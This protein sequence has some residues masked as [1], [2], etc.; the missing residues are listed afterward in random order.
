MSYF[1][2]LKLTKLGETLLANINGNLNETLTFTSGEIGAGI[3]NNDD[4]I[5][6]LTTLKEK[7]KD[8]D[9]ISIEKDEKDETIVK[10]EL[11]FSNIDLKEAKI[12]REIGIYAKGNNGEP[13]L[14]AYSNAGENY[15]YIPLPQ[16]NPQNFTIQINLKITSNSKIDAIINMAGFVTIGKMIEYL[17]NKLTQIPTIAE[18]QSRKNLKI[19]DIVEVLGYYSAGDGAGH[20]RII[21]NEDDGSGVQLNNGLWANIVHNGEVN[22][23]WFG[24]KG[25]GITD[26]SDVLNKII[27][28]CKNNN[29]NDIKFNSN[30]FYLLNKTIYINDLRSD[31]KQKR[32]TFDM[33]TKD[34]REGCIV[35]NT[36]AEVFKFTNCNCVDINLCVLSTKHSDYNSINFVIPENERKGCSIV[37]STGRKNKNGIEGSAHTFNFNIACYLEDNPSINKGLG[38][39]AIYNDTCE[40]SNYNLKN[41]VANTWCVL[42]RN[43]YL[44]K[45]PEN[46]YKKSCKDHWITSKIVGIYKNG[47]VFFID[48][49]DN[50]YFNGY[51][52]GSSSKSEDNSSF[53]YLHGSL[54]NFYIQTDIEHISYCIRGKQLN[55]GEL[56]VIG[57]NIHSL[58]KLKQLLNVNVVENTYFIKN[59]NV[60]YEPYDNSDSYVTNFNLYL[61]NISHLNPKK[62]ISAT[63]QTNFNVFSPNREINYTDVIKY[64][65]NE[66]TKEKAPIK[67]HTDRGVYDEKNRVSFQYHF[68]V[69]TGEFQLKAPGSL[70]INSAANSSI[71]GKGI[72]YYYRGNGKYSTIGQQGYRTIADANVTTPN[73]IGE[74]AIENGKLIIATGINRG[75]WSNRPTPATLNTVYHT[76]KMKQEGVYNDFITYM[77]EKTLYDKQQRNLE[78][79]RQLAYQEALKEN[80]NLTYEEFMSL[81]PMTLNLI[82]EPQPSARLQEFMDK[83]L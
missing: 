74:L 47:Q 59:S 18:L 56:K 61:G 79:E 55:Y 67:I 39:I 30:K 35:A 1:K 5:R 24:A 12:F 69:P 4:E 20:K 51:A 52:Y 73:F 57:I 70:F 50:F 62:I 63:K 36:G 66:T 10:L 13:V 31:F 11:Q 8:L 72:L 77:D 43:D 19:G 22:V 48:N 32:L 80:P 21:S 82:E 9:I 37:F 33:N 15:D 17:K 64:L 3:I 81:Q 60:I 25:D 38:T 58:I 75:E 71:D 78:K 29:T 45:Y 53:I 83:Y 2:G 65:E 42:T 44:G 68:G 41:G 40:V 54:Q 46:T 6:F 49:I 23:S 28:Y 34:Y 16:D 7:W 26:D 27:E 14:F 76:E